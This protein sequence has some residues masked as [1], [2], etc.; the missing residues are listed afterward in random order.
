MRATGAQTAEFDTRTLR[1]A[2]ALARPTVDLSPAMTVTAR[3]LAHDGATFEQIFR[4]IDWMGTVAQLRKR[5][6][7]RNIRPYSRR[8]K[9]GI[10]RSRLYADKQ[11]NQRPFKAG[12]VVHD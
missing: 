2:R 5:L 9:F 3:R 12:V 8:M 10:D 11:I 1:Q 4:A 7:D 6:R